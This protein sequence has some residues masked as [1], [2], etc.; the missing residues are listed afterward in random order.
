[1]P[2]VIAVLTEDHRTVERLFTDFE[3]AAQPDRKEEIIKDVVRELSVHAAAEEQLV[4]P[5]M[6]AALQDG[7]DDVDHAIDEHQQVKRL[8][9]DLEKLPAGE[10]ESDDTMRRLMQEI[11]SHV[12][13]EEGD[14]FPRLRSSLAAER[15][16]QMGGLV[17]N[18][19]GLLPTHPHPL[20][21]G[22]ATAQLLAGPLA[23]IADHLR[24][25]IDNVRNR[26]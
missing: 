9:A 6:R 8:L 10:P 19:K 13:E 25:F 12:A 24:D 4:Y 16:D 2:D 15:L 7:S 20:V 11:R 17:E 21:P 26:S 22:T 23:S 3:T 5:T 18:I 14:L 1:M